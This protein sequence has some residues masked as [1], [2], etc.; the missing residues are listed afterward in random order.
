MT[1]EERFMVENSA[2]W[3]LDLRRFFDPERVNRELRPLVMVPGYCMNS[4]I[5]NFHPSGVSMISY[6]TSLGFE[7]WATNLRG[8]GDSCP[9]KG[10]RRQPYGFQE[11]AMEDLP[12][13]L[14]FIEK[15]KLSAAEKVDL[16]GMSL[17]APICYTYLAH[18]ADEHQIGAMVAVG[19]PLRWNRVHPLVAFTMRSER[20]AGLLPIRGT[21]RLARAAVPLLTRFPRVLSVYLNPDI[22]DLTQI[23]EMIQ[24][25]DDPDQQLNAEIVRWI[26]NRDLIVGGRNICHSLYS[27]EVPL[28]CIIAGQDG[29]VTP[30]SALSVLDHIG[31]HDVEVLEVGSKEVPHAHADLFVS[32]GAEQKVFRPMGAWLLERNVRKEGERKMKKKGQGHA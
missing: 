25:V 26:R 5:L 24:T 21:R 12:A 13:A 9:K 11:L 16:A 2:G 8:Q 14:R 17:G 19:G 15:Q 32:H 27:V 3:E 18:H 29:I 31:S 1:Q 20:L 28:L 7:V 30:E 22:V 23:D 10:K 6:L 4:F